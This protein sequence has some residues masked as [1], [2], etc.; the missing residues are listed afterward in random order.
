MKDTTLHI[1]INSE[2]KEKAKAHA[3]ATGRTLASLIALL[4]KQEMEKTNKNL[5]KN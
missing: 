3:E 4:L 2:L 5:A 1:R